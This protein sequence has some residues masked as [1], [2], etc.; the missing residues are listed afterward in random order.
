[1]VV[2]VVLLIIKMYQVKEALVVE[3]LL[4]FLLLNTGLEQVLI[5]DLLLAGL[6]MEIEEEILHLLTQVVG[7]AVAEAVEALGA[8]V[9]K[10][11]IS[12]T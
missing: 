1:V 7:M 12:T 2:L 4:E 6:L 8:L 9:E 3:L 10:V 11:L 5:K